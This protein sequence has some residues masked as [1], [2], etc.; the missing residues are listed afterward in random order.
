M[1]KIKKTIT[2]ICMVLLVVVACTSGPDPTEMPDLQA[3]ANFEASESERQGV[4]IEATARAIATYMVEATASAM[5]TPT[6]V[7][8]PTPIPKPTSTLIP[9]PTPV[10]EE[11]YSSKYGFSL[12]YTAGWQMYEWDGGDT[13]LVTFSHASG[14]NVEV[15]I[16][17][18][19]DV[20]MEQFV[21][22]VIKGQ[23][24][25]GY[26]EESRYK[27]AEPYGYVT[28]GIDWHSEWPV[29]YLIFKNGDWGVYAKF[30]LNG[31]H[32]EQLSPVM[33]S[34]FSS[35]RVFPPTK[36]TPPPTPVPA[37]TSGY[38]SWSPDGTKIVFVSGDSVDSNF[39][40][41][42]YVMDSDGSG[43][44]KLTN[45]GNSMRPTWSPD[46]TKIAFDSEHFDG[47][48]VR[49]VYVMNEDGS[50]VVNLT[51]GVTGISAMPSWSPDGSK[52]LFAS[53]RDGGDGEIFLSNADGSDEVQL[54]DNEHEDMMP[55][56]CSDGTIIAFVSM[57]E[58]AN[59]N[60]D[61][62]TM[63]AD[64]T[65]QMVKIYDN[66]DKGEEEPAWNSDCSRMAFSSDRGGNWDVYITTQIQ[67]N[68]SQGLV[69][70]T[71]DQLA[72]DGY[73]MWSPDGK[74][75]LFHS[76]RS[77]YLQIYIL[78]TEAESFCETNNCNLTLTQLTDETTGR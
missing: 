57:R 64:G 70:V 28:E 13:N 24:N 54:T 34:M 40:T 4:A 45:K 18:V 48:G 30:L 26:G 78:S 37:T 9:D 61:I 36:L 49:H 60:K 77:G 56:W 52:I 20:G 58:E 5:P 51:K 29:E 22:E 67:E 15:T 66:V 44:T 27:N 59:N 8:V 43:L 53:G 73:P 14:S 74:K 19:P 11:T 3:T 12:N 50:N 16:L 23:K 39:T 31:K 35:F 38:G 10:L 76:Q 32:Q 55:T 63:N 47:E 17:Y 42:V 2:L 62:Y 1:I 6:I 33:Q 21:E 65:D 41:F 46:G 25:A 7:P 75:L 71:P 68:G 69:N 72:T